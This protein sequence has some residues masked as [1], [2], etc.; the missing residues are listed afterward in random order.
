MSKR[1]INEQQSKRIHQKQKRYQ[2]HASA[3]ANADSSLRNGLVITRFSRIALIEDEHQQHHRCAIRADVN[4]LVAGDRVVWQIEESR[5]GVIVSV[6][7]RETVLSRADFRGTAK[8]VAANISQIM[9]VV[10]PV[11]EISWTL[12]D[13]YL[14]M[15]QNLSLQAAV[16]LNKIDLPCAELKSQ[17]TNCYEPLGYSLYFLHQGNETLFD[18]LEQGLRGQTSVFVG[19]SGVGKSSIIGKILP[20]VDFIQTQ[21]ISDHSNLGRHTT[22]NAYLYHLPGGGSLIDSPGVREFRLGEIP[23]RQLAQ[24]FREFR[25]YITQCQFRNCIHIDAQGCALINAV[26]QGLVAMSRYQSYVKLMNQSVGKV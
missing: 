18:S 15:A 11:P 21:A 5:Q 4:D 17:L 25:P 22:S 8:T 26:N 20:H 19:Q 24:G 12:L 2:H 10:A 6:Y 14:V 13:S 3:N 1:R 23:S 7:P 9:I 16:V